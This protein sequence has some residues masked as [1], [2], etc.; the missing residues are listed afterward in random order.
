[1]P[2]PFANE[3]QPVTLLHYFYHWEQQQPNKLYL[4][5]PVGDRYTDYTWGEVGQQARRLAT[6]LN[7]LNLPPKSNVGLISKN[8]AH[9]IIADLAILISGHVS[10]PFYPTLTGAQLEQVLDHSQCRVLIV[11]KIDNWLSLK[12]SVPESLP[13]IAFPDYSPNASPPDPNHTQWQAIQDQYEPLIGT[14]EAGIDEVFTIVYTSGTTGNPKG[15]MIS[16]RAV[17]LLI[18]ACKPYVYPDL[19][20]ARFFAYLQ[21]CHMAERSLVE[22]FGLYAGGT[23]YFAESLDA[24][25]KNLA[26][27]RPTHL[28]SVPRIWAKFQQGILTKIPQR[29]LDILLRIPVVSNLVKLK[30]RQGLG[31]NDARLMVTGAAPMPVPLIEWFRRLGIRIQEAYGQTEATAIISF[32]PP[33]A[34]KDGT[35]G[36]LLDGL[37]A[38]VDPE[39]GGLLVRSNWLMR[40]YYREPGLTEAV[41]QNDWLATGDAGDIDADGYLRITGRVKDSYKSP[42]GEYIAPLQIELGFADNS[43]IDQIYVGGQHLPQPIA[44]VVLSDTGKQI[45]RQLVSQSLVRTV[46]ELNPRLYP[47]EHVRKVIV[48]RDSWSVEN[49]RLTPTMKI[50]RNVIE[51][52]YRPQME[53]WF[54][55]S[56]TIIWEE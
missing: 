14:S 45:G 6:Y 7:A 48:V 16:Y 22:M 55:R 21:L 13:C 27:A 54:S 11:G 53:P 8:C 42:K 10:V 18:Q 38:R 29:K 34:I 1:M 15:V 31:L 9:W 32:M 3:S 17:W 47:Y 35:V 37:E 2:T 40:G 19:P 36:K 39:T 30:I 49:N 50:K 44:L 23:I 43:Y 56:E 4:R 28:T 12:P 26:T 20:D 33:N 41:L 5:Q 25:A 51:T 46:Q 52:H 24:F